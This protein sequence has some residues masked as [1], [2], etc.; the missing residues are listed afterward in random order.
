MKKNYLKN[1]GVVSIPLVMGVGILLFLIVISITSVETARL[2]LVQAGVDGSQALEYAKVGARDAL[3]HI[4]RDSTFGASSTAYE[5]NM[6]SS[7]CVSLKGC[8]KVVVTDNSTATT[9][10]RIVGSIGYYKSARKGIEVEVLYDADSLGQITLV[11]TKETL[12][13]KG[14]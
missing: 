2:Y 6:I 1:K 10:G 13:P 11:K 7:G 12:T 14:F 8:A 9:S 4:A 3:E 5:I